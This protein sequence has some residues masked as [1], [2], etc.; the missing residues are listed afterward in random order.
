MFPYLNF[1]VGFVAF[2]YVLE[3]YLDIRQHKNYKIKVIPDKIK[4]YDL[5]T[6]EQFEKSQLYGIDKRYFQLLSL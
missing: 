1:I 6:Q 4:S 3:T 5:I 2:S